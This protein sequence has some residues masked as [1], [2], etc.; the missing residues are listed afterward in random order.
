MLITISI[1][2]I[3]FLLTYFILFRFE[4]LLAKIPYINGKITYAFLLSVNSTFLLMI[5]VAVAIVARK[6]HPDSFPYSA[7]FLFVG[8]WIGRWRRGHKVRKRR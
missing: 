7:I 6:Y 2:V 1:C 5:P 4:E 3:I 8:F